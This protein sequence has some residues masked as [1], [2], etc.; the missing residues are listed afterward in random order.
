MMTSTQMTTTLVIGLR[1]CPSVQLG[2]GGRRWTGPEAPRGWLQQD[3]V[4]RREVVEPVDVPLAVDLCQDV[5]VVVVPQGSTQLVVV[6]VRLAL[7]S[8]P[9]LSHLV[10][11]DELEFAGSGS[12]SKV[13]THC[14]LEGRFR[15][16]GDA[17]RV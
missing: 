13:P 15:L 11:V 7:S 17:R 9:A 1:F 2:F 16:P 10:R 4:L 6:H 3:G 5:L 8:A 14:C 12:A